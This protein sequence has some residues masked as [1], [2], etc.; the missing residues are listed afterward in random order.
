MTFA[1]ILHLIT[2]LDLY[3]V[4]VS[5]QRKFDQNQLMNKYAK[6]FC[7]N[8]KVPKSLSHVVF[9]IVCQKNIPNEG[10]KRAFQ[11]KT[12]LDIH[13]KSS[14]STYY[15]FLGERLWSSLFPSLFNSVCSRILKIL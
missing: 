8:H 10:I 12:Y 3:I 4:I 5:N 14:S 7:K 13:I 9:F 2:N 15:L 1:V 11:R 6:E